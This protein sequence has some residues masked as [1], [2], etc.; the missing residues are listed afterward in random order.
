MFFSP[1]FNSYAFAIITPLL[2]GVFVWYTLPTRQR[3]IL[4]GLRTIMLFLLILVLLRPTIRT[5]DIQQTSGSV[6]IL[7]DTSRSMSV[8]D[9]Q[10]LSSPEENSSANHASDHG[11]SRYDEMRRALSLSQKELNLM[12]ENIRP[13]IWQFNAGISPL[14]FENGSISLPN[15][16]SGDQS[17]LGWAIQ[18]SLTHI[19]GQ[20][21]LGVILLSDGA[22]RSVPPYDL[23]P[24][25]AVNTLKHQEIPLYTVCF[26]HPEQESRNHDLAVDD[27]LADQRVFVGNELTVSG[28][29]RVEGFPGQD[30]PVELH[31]ENHRGEME[32]VAR[33]TVRTEKAHD[34][35][36][37]TLSWIPRQ[38]GEVKLSLRVPHMKEELSASNNSLE[39]FVNVI[40]GGISVLYLEGAFRPEMSFLKRSLGHSA[41]IQ[42]DV[43]RLDARAP[44]NRPAD[45]LQKLSQGY[46]VYI[47]GDVDAS[48]FTAAEMTKLAESVSRGAGLLT[49]GGFQT[50]GSGGYATTPLA[51]LFPLTMNRLQRLNPRDPVAPDMHWDVPISMMPS[52]E[53]NAHFVMSLNR[54]PQKSL[55]MWRKLP[56]LHGANRFHSL[57]PAAITLAYAQIQQEDGTL[58]DVPLLV[59]Q[60]Y[61]KGRVISFAADSTWRWWMHGHEESH[62][63]FWRQL[64]LWLAQ[65]DE[66][67]EGNVWISLNQRRFTREQKISFQVGA[68]LS[69]G[70]ILL[71][72]SM[73]DSSQNTDQ[74]AKTKWNVSLEL[75]SGQH[76]PIRL[77]RGTE[78][79]VGSLASSLPEGDYTIHASVT[80][81]GQ[82]IGET[83]CRFNVYHVDMEL[84]NAQADP[85]LMESLA[86]STGGRAV[87][88][89]ELPELWKQFTAEKE[90]LQ[91]RREVFTP[92]WDK[93]WILMLMLTL[94]CVEW[95]L[96]KRS[97]MV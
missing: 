12:S 26:G 14:K 67:L 52:E 53:G 69:T 32:M 37:V 9:S 2:L 93:S 80:H 91:I 22:Q 96:R 62:K 83:R 68:R 43:I 64:T 71:Q 34:S 76:I 18:N 74:N 10:L 70:E 59:E 21:I 89:E 87:S 85:A 29:I 45:L 13:Y 94:L 61:G 42:L 46:A 58:T 5:W 88:P 66:T 30:I 7:T 82:V 79:M 28:R 39:A 57:K 73:P 38:P 60:A 27:L 4:A 41:D 44:Q 55:E 33:T 78:S 36:P 20:R 50:Y 86:V 84:D 6:I 51:P 25:T 17:A 49:L 92:L 48:S 90:N 40:K 56:P 31:A 1:I 15:I 19:S 75:P 35:I 8:T 77:S 63:R 65:K 54:D 81:L 24:Q 11:T 16:P 95:F 3:W 47:L 23:F 72:D 97:G